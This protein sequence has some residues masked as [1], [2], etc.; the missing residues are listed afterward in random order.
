MAERNRPGVKKAK[1]KAKEPINCYLCGEVCDS[2]KETIS[3]Q[4]APTRVGHVR[5]VDAA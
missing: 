3:I 5:C 2:A 1:A 4:I